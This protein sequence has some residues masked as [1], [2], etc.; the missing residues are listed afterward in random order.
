MSEKYKSRKNEP[1]YSSTY[2]NGGWPAREELPT[3]D[4][5]GDVDYTNSDMVDAIRYKSTGLHSDKKDLEKDIDEWVEGYKK[6]KSDWKKYEETVKPYLVRTDNKRLEKKVKKCTCGTHSIDKN[7]P[8]SAHSD[9]CDL[10]K[11]S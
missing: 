11:E 7:A 9:Y 3:K 1:V 4:P 6:W 5:I 2:D 8:V 10:T